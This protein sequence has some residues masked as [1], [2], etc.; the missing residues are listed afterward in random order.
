MGGTIRFKVISHSFP[1]RILRFRSRSVVKLAQTSLKLGIVDGVKL[2]SSFE[3][4]LH[5][6]QVLFSVSSRVGVEMM[7][8]LHS[9]ADLQEL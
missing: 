7:V 9:I 6:V 4:N 8:A 5:I 2:A 1:S 3:E